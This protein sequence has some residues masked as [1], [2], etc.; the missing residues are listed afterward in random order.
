MRVEVVINKRVIEVHD[1]PHGI[2]VFVDGRLVSAVEPLE[3]D[4]TAF[5]FDSRRDEP[6]AKIH[7]D[8]ELRFREC[9]QELMNQ[10][11]MGDIFIGDYEIDTTSK[12]V[13]KT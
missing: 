11:Q 6:I 5:I 3:E 1:S 4:V 2:E 7:W 12:R 10:S 9:T 13:E 8:E